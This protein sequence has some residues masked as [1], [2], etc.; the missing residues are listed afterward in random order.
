MV[1]AP[2]E[3][4]ENRLSGGRPR[5]IK[6]DSLVSNRLKL[7]GNESY[8]YDFWSLKSYRGMVSFIYVPEI[9]NRMP[10]LRGMPG[11]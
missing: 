8:L 4:R 1:L 11:N 6:K 2:I 10:H 3:V 7:A 9:G 5:R